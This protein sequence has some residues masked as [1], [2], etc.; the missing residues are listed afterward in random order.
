MKRCLLCVRVHRVWRKILLFVLPFKKNLSNANNAPVH[1]S[2]ELSAVVHFAVRCMRINTQEI[3]WNKCELFTTVGM[4][5]K[6]S[7]MIDLMWS[8]KWNAINESCH[9]VKILIIIKLF[10]LKPHL[11]SKD[12]FLDN[13]IIFNCLKNIVMSF[14][15]ANS[16]NDHIGNDSQNIM[17]P[18]NVVH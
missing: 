4:I 10:Y 7:I 6:N 2:Y 5:I 18:E 9:L 13:W 17:Q 8:L 12:K 15:I 14:A 16:I 3:R 1:V 11:W